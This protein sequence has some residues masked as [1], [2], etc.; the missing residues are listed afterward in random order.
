MEDNVT[1][2]GMLMSQ[3][4]VISNKVK[5]ILS[6]ITSI[7]NV[8]NK[9]HYEFTD[10]TDADFD[11]QG[12]LDLDFTINYSTGHLNVSGGGN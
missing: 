8:D 1:L 6:G 11:V 3:I 4:T 7:T 5:T 10:G 12:E 9:L 2:F